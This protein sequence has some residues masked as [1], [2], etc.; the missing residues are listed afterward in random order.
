MATTS[1][2][3]LISIS[4][5]VILISYIQDYQRHNLQKVNSIVAKN[6]AN[7]STTTTT[8]VESFT[9][10]SSQFDSEIR[11]LLSHVLVI[12]SYWCNEG[13]NNG[14]EIKYLGHTLG[15]IRE[16]RLLP[17]VG[18]VTVVI[19]TNDKENAKKSIGGDDWYNFHQINVPTIQQFKETNIKLKD[20]NFTIN[21][22]HPYHMPF[23]HRE[24]IADYL[25][26]DKNGTNMTD[27][28][29]EE[30]PPPSTY[31]YFEVDNVLDKVGLLS[32]A[33]DMAL[34]H[35]L[36][37][38]TTNHLRHFFRWEYSTK[39]ECVVFTGQTKS[40][41]RNTSILIGDKE[42]ITLTDGGRWAGMYVLPAEHMKMYY[43]SGSF[44]NIPQN[45]KYAREI[46]L[47][48]I[49]HG[50]DELGRKGDGKGVDN[51]LVPVD[52]RT[53]TVSLSAGV[54]HQSD[55]YSKMKTRFS[56]LCI[57]DLFKM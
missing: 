16:W 36:G 51:T 15:T 53:G 37:V 43:H 14:G 26:T 45:T 19:I 6:S 5:C 28:S 20:W 22:N 24:V 49:V 33:E 18:N 41:L 47:Q 35:S 44:W 23:Y 56:K 31:A 55:K 57:Q 7:T 1:S 10:T 4:I 48:D 3:C 30:L 32:W 50:S 27:M 2:F 17:Q 52:E 38:E 42:F 54:H 12:I 13:D 8:K 40:I 39:N 25:D 21:G 11:Q 9:G 46:Q 29:K 34:L